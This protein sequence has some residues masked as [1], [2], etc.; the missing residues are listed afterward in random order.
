MNA[1]TSK[2]VILEKDLK[3]GSYFRLDLLMN[4]RYGFWFEQHPRYLMMIDE[5]IQ[6]QLDRPAF[7]SNSPMVVSYVPAGAVK[8]LFVRDS[9]FHGLEAEVVQVMILD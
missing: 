2:K 3:P 8:Q 4:S 7:R 5:A 1:T 9:Y 6:V